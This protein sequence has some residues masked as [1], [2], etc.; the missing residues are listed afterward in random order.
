VKH[1][2]C[3]ALASVIAVAAS[4][5][6]SATE[7]ANNLVVR[8]LIN[9][10]SFEPLPASPGYTKVIQVLQQQSGNAGA[11]ALGAWRVARF[12]QQPTC[13][14]VAYA[15]TQPD[16]KR[17]FTAFGGELN[18]CED[19]GP[20]LRECT[21]AP[22]VLVPANSRCADGSAPHDTAEV[23]SAIQAALVRGGKTR[24]QVQ[25]MLVKEAAA[26]QAAGAGVRK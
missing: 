8:A 26:R 16:T 22:G 21:S 3:L 6:A 20:P 18:I 10:T 17:V 9:G 15:M 7:A 13:G 19:G 11:I 1:S 25:E 24:E 12:T 5:P 4:Q 2:A 14:R 23:A